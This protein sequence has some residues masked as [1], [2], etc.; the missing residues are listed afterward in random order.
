M[1]LEQ[2]KSIT[3]RIMD[4]NRKLADLGEPKIPINFIGMAGVGKCDLPSY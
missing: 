1:N 2:V 3:N 4:V